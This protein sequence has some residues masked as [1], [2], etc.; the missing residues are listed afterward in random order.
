M[1]P[2]SSILD[3][4][5]FGHLPGCPFL[6]EKI[7]QKSLYP[8]YKQTKMSLILVKNEEK[9]L[10]ENERCYSQPDSCSHIFAY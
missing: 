10:D 4:S 7:C 5:G 3:E 9:K 1:E 6:Q 2:M 8:C